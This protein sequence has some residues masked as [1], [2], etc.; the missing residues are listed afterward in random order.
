MCTVSKCENPNEKGNCSATRR[1]LLNRE[2]MLPSKTR[3]VTKGQEKSF[4]HY[5]QGSLA[6]L[7][8]HLKELYEKSAKGRMSMRRR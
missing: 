5:V 1:V 3:G 6:P 7:P 8:E 4:V 2:S